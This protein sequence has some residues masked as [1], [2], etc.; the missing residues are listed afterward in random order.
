MTDD[1]IFSTKA[2]IPWDSFKRAILLYQSSTGPEILAF[3]FNL[4]QI[5]Q[6]DFL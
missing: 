3:V 4:H 1:P 6:R 2:F 5:K